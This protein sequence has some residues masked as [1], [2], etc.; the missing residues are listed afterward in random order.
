MKL[1]KTEVLKNLSD[2]ATRYNTYGNH[3]EVSAWAGLVVYG[4]FIG[5]ITKSTNCVG[6]EVAVTT[7]VVVVA[8]LLTLLLIQQ[9]SM[10]KYA[11]DLMAVC[12]L[13]AVKIIGMSD[14]EFEA[15]DFSLKEPKAEAPPP[16]KHPL[17]EFL[18]KFVNPGQPQAEDTLPKCLFE[19]KKKMGTVGYGPGNLLE[20]TTYMLLYLLALVGLLRI[21]L[22]V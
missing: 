4:V 18:M 11:S 6:Y 20:A 7:I 5:Q 1:N 14:E 21:W 19:E 2:T 8:L 22:L 13:L 10:K 9:F 16:A 15:C 12:E 17:A 3:K